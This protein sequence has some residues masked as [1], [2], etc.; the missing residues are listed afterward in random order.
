ML[1]LFFV[2]RL[3]GNSG[4][5]KANIFWTSVS[6]VA[7]AS[8]WVFLLLAD[9]LQITVNPVLKVVF[10]V[11]Y[12]AMGAAKMATS[13]VSNPL[14]FD[15]I[16]YEFSRSGRY[17]PA[18]VNTAYSFVDKLISSLATTIVAVSVASIGYTEGMPQATDT[19]TSGIF[20]IATF[21]WLGMPIL[22]YVC[23]L[24][25]MHWYKLD[26]E[27][28]EEVQ[29]KNTETRA[30]LKAARADGQEATR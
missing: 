4:L 6:I 18:V 15:I 23:T 19:L 25:A 5:K 8:M 12:C 24:V 21:L 3:A 1:L 9:T 10:I 28:M 29:R 30:A 7:Y 20:W 11:L 16:D 13:C 26:K 22:G 2:S 17:M 27:T 14:R